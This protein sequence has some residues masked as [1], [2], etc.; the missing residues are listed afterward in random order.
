MRTTSEQTVGLS[1][2]ALGFLSRVVR[3]TTIQ[4]GI[5]LLALLYSPGPAFGASLPG[6]PSVTLAWNTSAGPEVVG[7]RVHL[8]AASGNYTSSVMVGNVTINTVPGL[9]SGLTYYFAVTA[10]DAD[11]RESLFSNEISF[12]PGLPTLQI[13]LTAVGQ[14]VLTVSGRVG[15]TCEIQVTQDFKV[16]TAIGTVMLGAGGSLDFTDPSAAYRSRR[17][18]RARVIQ[19]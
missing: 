17:F 14:A 8:G 3:R 18:Y 10:Y 13:H 6:S 16:W 12:V 2:P 9:T 1:K 4:G 11:G 19:I 7:Y 15:Q 5:L